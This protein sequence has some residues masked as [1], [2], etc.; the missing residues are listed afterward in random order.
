M[1]CWVSQKIIKKDKNIKGINI[2]LKLYLFK[3]K[4]I[5][6]IAKINTTGIVLSLIVIENI[7]KNKNKIKFFSEFLNFDSYNKIKY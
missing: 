6:V 1:Y 2:F 4:F 5:K 7:E 3:N